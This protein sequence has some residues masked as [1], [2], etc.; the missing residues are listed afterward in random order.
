M[1]IFKKALILLTIFTIQLFSCAG[2]WSEMYVKDEN[3]NFTSPS[4][5]GLN[6]NNSLYFLSNSY[7][8]HADRFEYFEKV[9]KNENIKAWQSYLGGSVSNK[10][11]ENIFY[12]N[13]SVSQS[14]K[15]YSTKINKPQLNSYIDFLDMQMPFANQDLY[16]STKL[17]NY[18]TVLSTGI[19]LFNF[20]KDKFLK[21]RY[22]FLIM[23]LYHYN[24]EYKKA[25]DFYSKNSSL[26][27]KGSVIDEWTKA[28]KAGALQNLG[29][30]NEANM[31][32][33]DIFKN[34]KTNA[35]LGY[36]DFKVTNDS[37][38][39]AL[40]SMTKNN[41]EKAELYFLRAMNW[42][43]SHLL[44]LEN[45]ANIAPESVW[46]ERLSFM[47]MQD[48][49]NQRYS[50]MQS[51]A[52]RQY[53]YGSNTKSY[54]EQMVYYRK[55]LQSLKNPSF[56]SQ[57]A[58][59]YLDVLS[60]KN[61]DSSKM[62]KLRS[63]A[64]GSN[65]VY[66]SL[67]EYLDRLNKTKN[68][69]EVDS[70][71]TN[72]KSLIA[73]LPKEQ[74]ISLIRYSVLQLST[75]YPKDSVNQIIA[76]EYATNKYFGNYNVGSLLNEA[77]ADEFEQ[78]LTL[79]NRTFLHKEVF[80][81]IMDKSKDESFISSIAGTL[82]IQKNNFERALFYLNRTKT[83]DIAASDYNPFNAT[84]SGNN[85]TGKKASYNQIKFATTM[86]E[87]QNKI[88]TNTA[89]ATDYYLYATGLYNKSWFGSFPGSSVYTR[90]TYLQ[91]TKRKIEDLD[92]AQKYYMKALGYA[93][94]NEMRAKISY[95]LLKIDFARMML[96][97]ANSKD[98]I[99]NPAFDDME[100]L[101]KLVNVNPSF[102]QKLN[103][104]KQSYSNTK[105]GSEAI[106]SCVSFRSFL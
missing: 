43:N 26:I 7:G 84:I 73:S 9:K 20:T 8:A 97:N 27:Q 104:Y 82:F 42:Q 18:A 58:L 40:L 65:L 23:R 69:N 1:S 59:L 31:L 101:R 89:N 87:L 13:L 63:A 98:Q 32:Y 10:D 34:N 72:L 25:L 77:D 66:V 85:R 2:G 37:Q 19:S 11:I 48:L 71:T 70:L 45:I 29:Y 81:K 105:Y 12:S 17:K 38:W 93:K 79:K 54:N 60:Y 3:Y 15:K 14:Y 5:I 83:D 30:L 36:Y 106:R 67:L 86:L 74:Q 49:Q 39:N 57:Y 102:R 88:K 80:A 68:I 6:P 55:I 35:Y 22:L 76:R 64:I 41:D 100:D 52:G 92:L 78:Y 4:M 28:L 103:D 33:A 50:I 46:F 24:G 91:V 56:F 90:S 51:S 62:S 61:L 99:W 96:K 16:D 94:D 47:V 95:Q 53:Y 44:E 21:E 75:L